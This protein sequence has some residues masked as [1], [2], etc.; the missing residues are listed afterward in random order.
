[1]K[2]LEKYLN[3]TLKIPSK[4]KRMT[5]CKECKYFDDTMCYKVLDGVKL[6]YSTVTV[7]PDFGCIF[8]EK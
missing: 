5:R 1:M 2:T 4:N 7:D 6:E 3:E 8:A